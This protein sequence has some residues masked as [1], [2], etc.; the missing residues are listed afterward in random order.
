[1]SKDEIRKLIGGYASGTLTAEE[2]MQL[3]EAALEDQELFDELQREQELKEL[4]EDPVSRAEIRHALAESLPQPAAPW[5]RR[6]WIWAVGASMA[7][8]AVTIA[9]LAPW[10]V[11]VPQPP[12]QTSAR[13]EA[14]AAALTPRVETPAQPPATTP[15]RSVE[16]KPRVKRPPARKPEEREQTSA[17]P[18][19]DIAQVEA[20]PPAAPA[21]A[22]VKQQPGVA[23]AVAPAAAPPPPAP[24]DTV[25]VRRPVQAFRATTS[26]APLAKTT[27]AEVRMLYRLEKRLEDG[28][29]VP[30]AA[31]AVFHL[32][33]VVRI[34]PLPRRPGP[35]SVEE[36][37]P[38]TSSWTPLTPPFEVTVKK[39]ERLRLNAGGN[40]TVLTLRTDELR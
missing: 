31:N 33:D 40:G 16:P 21:P 26:M 22:P 20:P 19:T 13:V 3:F 9:V 32:N 18:V 1:M 23:P 28:T 29:Y 8:A 5:F 10:R 15:V 34:V 11:A 39:D 36:W 4:L 25:E 38:A 27:A 2:K 30:A 7:A 6:P 35:V 14:P 24:A 17:T 12:R 37:D